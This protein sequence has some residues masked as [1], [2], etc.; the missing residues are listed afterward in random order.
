MYKSIFCQWFWIL[1]CNQQYHCYIWFGLQHIYVT[2]TY[3]VLHC[4]CDISG[5]CFFF[6]GFG[7][8]GFSMGKIWINL[9]VLGMEL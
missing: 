8:L 3:F 7:I 9:L 2:C 4:T 1:V 5:I 6:L